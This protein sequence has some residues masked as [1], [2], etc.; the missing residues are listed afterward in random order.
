MMEFVLWK[1]YMAK[2]VDP[3]WKVVILWLGGCFAFVF[4]TSYLQGASGAV[5]FLFIA[6]WVMGV[7]VAFSEGKVTS[8]GFRRAFVKF[9][10]YGCY[11]GAARSMDFLIPDKMLD[12]ASEWRMAPMTMVLTGLAFNDLVSLFEKL[13]KLGI[14]VD[15]R[16]VKMVTDRLGSDDSEVK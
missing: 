14:G 2:M 5:L 6:D 3:A 12:A 1:G 7:G 13:K 10:A 15:R 16:L 4:P 9:I 8:K 11:I